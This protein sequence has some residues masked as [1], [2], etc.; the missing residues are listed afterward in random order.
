[1]FRDINPGLQVIDKNVDAYVGSRK[2]DLPD[3]IF[4]SILDRRISTDD[5]ECRAKNL[6]ARAVSENVD[7]A[8]I[9]VLR[10]QTQQAGKSGA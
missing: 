7:T 10:Q 9:G 2:I 8:G 4:L 6:G 1:M 5:I 3:A